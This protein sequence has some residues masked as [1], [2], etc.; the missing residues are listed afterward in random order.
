MKYIYM[1]RGGGK[2]RS[3][4]LCIYDAPAR[5]GRALSDDLEKSG[6]K[7]LFEG[8]LNGKTARKDAD[9][10]INKWSFNLKADFLGQK[11]PR[12]GIVTL[13][14]GTDHIDVKAIAEL[15][16]RLEACPEF[17]SNSVAELALTLA[18]RATHKPFPRPL[19]PG[20]VIFSHYSDEYA[21]AAVAQI[22]MRSRRLAQHMQRAKDF[23]Y[24]DADGR[25]PSEPWEDAELS[26][27]RIGI[28]GKDQK[29]SKLAKMLKLGFGCQLLGD[30]IGTC[31]RPYNVQQVPLAELLHDSDYVFLCTEKNGSLIS[32]STVISPSLVTPE[33]HLTGSKVAVLGT[34]GI[35]FRIAKA[36]QLGFNC[37]VSTFNTTSAPLESVMD[38]ADFV[39]IA[40]PLNG[41]TRGILGR[42]ELG[43]VSKSAP[44]LV[45]VTRDALVDSKRLLYHLQGGTIRAY[46][47]DVLP[48]DMKLW[49]GQGA[50]GITRLF[51]EHPKVFATPHYG[52]CSKNS[53][54]RMLIEVRQKIKILME[55]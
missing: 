27:L 29:A 37:R 8:L 2:A 35:G 53:L 55:G 44:V 5:V 39:F 19:P 33:R 43:L 16:L 9:V 13:T 41:S 4:R 10:W 31:M 23:S 6:H 20:Q 26:S 25:R 36:A 49:S 46:G 45:N 47:T 40:L 18:L 48:D 54:E 52:D 7:V 51:A 17:S 30:E 14:A 21:E 11:H 28:A 1:I 32:S 3:I 15:G 24:F 12:R 38:G 50:E 22:A 42:K 34:G